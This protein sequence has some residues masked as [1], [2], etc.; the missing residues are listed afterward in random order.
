[1]SLQEVDDD[2]EYEVGM[3]VAIADY[4]YL[5]GGAGN[6]ARPNAGN[7]AAEELG[8]FCS[9][10]ELGKHHVS[11]NINTFKGF[12]GALVFL[13]DGLR[14]STSVPPGNMLERSL[15][16]TRGITAGPIRTFGFKIGKSSPPS[17]T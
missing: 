13:V 8:F 7:V 16:Y 15:Q 1:M 9:P 11:Y 6:V 17:G 12:P 2:I 10:A 4:L 14:Q 3:K 5:D